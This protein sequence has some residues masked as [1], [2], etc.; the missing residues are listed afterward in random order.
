MTNSW[1]LRFESDLGNFGWFWKNLAW[2]HLL[3]LPGITRSHKMVTWWWTWTFQNTPNYCCF[4][5]FSD[6]PW[7]TRTT[8]VL[9]YLRQCIGV[10][11]K[12]VVVRLLFYRDALDAFLSFTHDAARAFSQQIR[13]R[14]REINKTTVAHVFKTLIENNMFIV[15]KI[16]KNVYVLVFQRKRRNTFFYWWRYLATV[17]KIL[18][19]C[20]CIELNLKWETK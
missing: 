9:F 3:K 11:V 2:A 20:T 6:K 18:K 16:E 15:F 8:C 12:S 19:Q 10:R 17:Y 13:V 5:Y 1:E 7:Q 4:I 14:V